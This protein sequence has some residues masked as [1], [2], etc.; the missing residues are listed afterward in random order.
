MT[1]TRRGLAAAAA[2]MLGPD[3]ARARP[4]GGRCVRVLTDRATETDRAAFRLPRGA[5]VD[6]AVLA[7][8]HPGRYRAVLSPA[9]QFLLAEALRDRG[10]TLSAAR[11]FELI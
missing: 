10:Q 8:L 6:V 3:L 2:L 5:M 9:N 1:L 11:E 4:T 7:R